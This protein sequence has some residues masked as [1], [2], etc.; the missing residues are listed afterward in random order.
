MTTEKQVYTIGIKIESKERYDNL[1]EAHS[2][3]GLFGINFKAFFQGYP[4]GYPCLVQY[5]T[6][7]HPMGFMYATQLQGIIDDDYKIYL[8]KGDED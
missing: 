3:D 7:A 6:D 2:K 8:T 1:M 5:L 4:E